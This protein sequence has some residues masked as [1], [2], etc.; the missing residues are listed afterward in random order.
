MELNNKYIGTVNSTVRKMP[1][2]TKFLMELFN[3]NQKIKRYLEYNTPSP[4]NE[5]ALSYNGYDIVNQPDVVRDLQ[6]RDGEQRIFRGRFDPDTITQEKCGLFIDVQ[7]GN[8]SY[9]NGRISCYINILIPFALQ[10]LDDE[11]T[12]RAMCIANEIANELDFIM[13]ENSV[14]GKEYVDLLGNISFKLKRV[15]NGRLSNKSDTEICSMLYEIETT[16]MRVNENG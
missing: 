4:L 7:S 15:D 3:K 12:T 11:Y 10:E 9:G 13:L 6:S 2:L 16:T 14:H 8:F 5:K 1:I